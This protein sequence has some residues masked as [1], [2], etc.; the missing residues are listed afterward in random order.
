[1]NIKETLYEI[2]KAAT[3]L[4]H[5]DTLIR[6]VKRR[7]HRTASTT[8]DAQSQLLVWLS[9]YLHLLA[10]ILQCVYIQQLKK[11]AQARIGVCIQLRMQHSL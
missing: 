2:N 6:Q 9:Y 11:L 5:E 4:R 8:L 10:H 3:D 1:M 7:S